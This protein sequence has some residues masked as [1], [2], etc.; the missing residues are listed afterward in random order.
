MKHCKKIMLSVVACILCLS[1]LTSCFHIAKHAPE[2]VPDKYTVG[3]KVDLTAEMFSIKESFLTAP[4]KDGFI[5]K[6]LLHIKVKGYDADFTYYNCFVTVAWHYKE[7]SDAADGYQ[8]KVFV[9]TLNLDATGSAKYTYKFPT[10][11]CRDISEIR[12][13]ITYSGRVARLAAD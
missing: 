9:T 11:A 8:E 12:A 2:G 5:P 10:Q 4:K 1:M 7:L 13:E 3:E 6:I